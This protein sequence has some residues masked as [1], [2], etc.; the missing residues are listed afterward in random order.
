MKLHLGLFV[1]ITIA[2]FIGEGSYGWHRPS[3]M[4]ELAA[5]LFGSMFVFGLIAVLK[6]ALNDR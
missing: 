2:V 3:V 1:L 5:I 4:E 6:E